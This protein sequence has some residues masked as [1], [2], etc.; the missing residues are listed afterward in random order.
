METLNCIDVDSKDFQE[1]SKA[2]NISPESLKSVAFS[3]RNKEGK[4]GIETLDELKE[5]IFNSDENAVTEEEHFKFLSEVIN[6]EG[7][8]EPIFYDTKEQA[9]QQQKNIDNKFVTHIYETND[10]RFMLVTPPPKLVEAVKPVS[11]ELEKPIT[12]ENSVIEVIGEK[13]VFKIR[14]DLNELS[15]LAT[16]LSAQRQTLL[17]A[18]D[19]NGNRMFTE[20]DLEVLSTDVA[21]G[22]SDFLSKLQENSE[23]FYKWFGSLF[24]G[25]SLNK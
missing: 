15:L 7:F 13:Q 9:I 17:N 16:K 12:P 25:R 1:K 24:L 11:I 19:D 3:L 20:S 5:A 6:I 10:S 14:K 18:K 2:L 22:L 23:T 4:E 21:F 8:N